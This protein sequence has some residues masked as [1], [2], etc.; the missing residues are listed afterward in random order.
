[1]NGTLQDRL[2]KAL[3]FA[4]INTIPEANTFLTEIFIPEFNAKFGRPAKNPL[5][6]LHTSLTRQER[7]MEH[8]GLFLSS[9]FAIHEERK[10][11]ND[12]TIRHENQF[13]QL[14]FTP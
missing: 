10:I 12:F 11:Q 8:D 1:M 14:Y 7:D 3:R 4:G 5:G 9:L 2:V 13:Y 6:N